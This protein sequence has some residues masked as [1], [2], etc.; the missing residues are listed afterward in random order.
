MTD[1]A[2]YR[3]MRARHWQ[4]KRL[5][6]NDDPSEHIRDDARENSAR[7]RDE[8]PQNAH[9]RCVEIEIL[10]QP[11]TNARDL[12]VVA[13]THQFLRRGRNPHHVSAVGAIP[14]VL[15]DDLTASV[16]VHGWPPLLMIRRWLGKC[17]KIKLF[18]S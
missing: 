14:A 15:S 7:E 2:G 4:Q 16:A 1:L 3:L 8:E 17:S 10:S 11:G 6:R 9:E 13:R 12:S 5:F 18:G